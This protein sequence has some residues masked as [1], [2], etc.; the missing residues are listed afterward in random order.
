M[1]IT[2]PLSVA[3]FDSLYKDLSAIESMAYKFSHLK[4]MGARQI[5]LSSYLEEKAKDLC[6]IA[7]EVFNWSN[8]PI[9]YEEHTYRGIIDKL[10]KFNDDLAHAADAELDLTDPSEGFVPG[11]YYRVVDILVELNG[12]SEL[13][14]KT[15]AGEMLGMTITNIVSSGI[16][17][18]VACV[19]PILCP[20]TTSA[21]EKF[22][23]YDHELGIKA[24]LADKQLFY[25]KAEREAIEEAQR[26]K[27]AD[28][29]RERQHQLLCE[30]SAADREYLFDMCKSKPALCQS[31]FKSEFISTITSDTVLDDNMCKCVMAVKAV[32]SA[33]SDVLAGGSALPDEVY[34]SLSNELKVEDII[35]ALSCMRPGVEARTLGT[36]E[37]LDAQFD[38]PTSV[39]DTVVFTFK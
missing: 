4:V 15:T 28:E 13:Y 17:P 32:M 21:V 8:Q 6:T 34:V 3:R 10:V 33:F 14:A 9:N 38:E 25:T 39:G 16:A 22:V 12:L 36:H 27:E 37:L 24:E 1:Q 23:P 26:R 5:N 11:A 20:G 7:T 2:I 30:Q 19:Y 35:L 18:Y 29:Q 31:L